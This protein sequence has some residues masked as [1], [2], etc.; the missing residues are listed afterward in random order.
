MADDARGRLAIALDVDD[1]VEA[2]RIAKAVKPYFGVAKV[3]LELYSAVGPDA[4]GALIDLGYD[5]FADIKLHDIP[6]TVG[7]SAAV[8]GALGVRWLNLH[9]SGG[10]DMLRA[11]VEGFLAGAERAGNPEPCALAVTVLTSDA[12]ASAEVLRARAALAVATGCA[13][14]VCAAGDVAVIRSVEPALVCVTPGIRPSGS[15]PNDQ[16]RAAT[17][18]AAIGAGADL[19]VVGRPVTAAEDRAAAAKAVHDEVVGALGAP[20]G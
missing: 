9:A 17:P 1:L 3:G 14:V 13:G 10:E 12:D 8:F 6:T 16:G 18:A 11:G 20:A 2:V 19:L 7:R 4:V 15:D 5:V